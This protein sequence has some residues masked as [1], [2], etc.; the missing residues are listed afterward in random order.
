M[1]SNI[2][3]KVS[4]CDTP[5]SSHQFHLSTKYL[6]K[7]MRLPILSTLI[8]AAENFNLATTVFNPEPITN[9]TI[10]PR[11]VS[12]KRG[13]IY[14]QATESLPFFHQPGSKIT[15]SSNWQVWPG[16]VGP[17]GAMGLAWLEQF[18]NVCQD[19]SFDFI[20]FHYSGDSVEGLKA[21]VQAV[22]DLAMR[23]PSM[24]KENGQPK[25]WLTEFAKNNE[26]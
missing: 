2:L 9:I 16:S 3:K 23:F 17:H 20:A 13:L 26:K 10:H 14:D 18:L 8:L 6:I 7:K 12:S 21:H 4:S 24:K 25:L 19:C 5:E 1:L 15:W 22:Y 11:A